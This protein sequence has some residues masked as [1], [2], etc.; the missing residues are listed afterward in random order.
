MEKGRHVGLAI[1]DRK[2]HVSQKMKKVMNSIN[3]FPVHIFLN[4]GSISHVTTGFTLTVLRCVNYVTLPIENLFGQAGFPGGS[5]VKRQRHRREEKL[6]SDCYLIHM[7][8]NGDTSDD[9]LS[10]ISASGRST[11][12]PIVSRP[13]QVPVPIN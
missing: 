13:T 10:V 1:N 6:A 4:P 2:C 8:L 3:C 7:F 5:L 9:I 11:A 12:T